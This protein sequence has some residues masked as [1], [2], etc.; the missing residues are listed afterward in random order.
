[1]GTHEIIVPLHKENDLLSFT[2][3]LATEVW[4][5]SFI[6]I[7]LFTLAMALADYL[8]GI[9][10]DWEYL[11]GFVLRNIFSETMGNL[12]DRKAYQK[13]ITC[14]WMFSS[15]LLV[16]CYAGNLTAM[17]ARPKLDRQIKK[18]EDFLHQEEITLVVEGGIGIVDKMRQSP[19]G[20]IMRSLIEKTLIMSY[21][22]DDNELPMNFDYPAEYIEDCFPLY[23]NVSEQYIRNYA[24][25]CDIDSIKSRLSDDFRDSG[26]CNWY[27]LQQTM[28]LST[29]S[30]MVFQVSLPH[31]II[32]IVHRARCIVPCYHLLVRSLLP[33]VN[34]REFL[35]LQKESPYLDDVNELID[36]G[37]QMGLI[38][39]EIKKKV[40]NATHCLTWNAVQD[41]HMRKDQNAVFHLE[42]MYGTIILFCF[43]LGAAIMTLLAELAI[44]KSIPR[45]K[46]RPTM[47]QVRE[48]ETT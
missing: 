15:F 39:N 33:S 2:K 30:V 47:I 10:V 5:F 19:N 8:A 9:E 46:T 41:S 17:I 35:V 4:I 11:V 20:S 16:M 43:G 45:G 12:R 1:M 21:D 6:T 44:H 3:P 31:L 14:I 38:E 23:Q 7:P 28:F 32:Y 24:S 26:K 18:H 37:N 13:F 36:L 27:I 40:P 48:H 42:D 29:P 22:D 25:I 34:G